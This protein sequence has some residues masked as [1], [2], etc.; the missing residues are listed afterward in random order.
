MRISSEQIREQNRL[1]VETSGQL[2]AP[3]RAR[4]NARIE[5]LR[6]SNYTDVES[7][8]SKPVGAAG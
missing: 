8:A 4:L 7:R 6:T 3:M 2:P 1:D 5:V